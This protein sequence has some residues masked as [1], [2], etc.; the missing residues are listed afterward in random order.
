MKVSHIPFSEVPFFSQMDRDYVSE[1]DSLRS[2]YKYPV[3]PE[4]FHDVIKERKSF[5]VDR[6]L[7]VDV[8]ESQ[9]KKLNTS[10]EQAPRLLDK[11]CFT[12]TTAHQPCLFTGPLYF[13]YK[14]CSAIH[15]SH[16]LKG[17]YPEYDFVPVFIIGG[18]D[19]DF[20]EMNHAHL[21]SRKITWENTESGPVGRMSSASLIPVLEEVK[22]ILGQSDHAIQLV[23]LLETSFSPDRT[24]GEC[25]QKF[26]I[27]LFRSQ[28]LIVLSMDSIQ[29]KKAFAGTMREEL[30]NNPSHALVKGTQEELT[31]KGFKTQAHAREINL[32]Y[33][34]ENGRDRI[35]FSD[36]KF[37]VLNQGISFTKDEIDQELDQYPERFS[38]NV[39]LRPLYQEKIL[40]NLAYI[41]GG[42]EIAY[43]LERKAQFAHFNLPF[44]MLIRRNSVIWID[45]RSVKM[46]KT[47]ELSLKE[48]FLPT[49]KIIN[50]W[51]QQHAVDE[52]DIDSE[53]ETVESAY[54]SIGEKANKLDPTL[55][56]AVEAERVKHIKL[57][58]HLG[59]RL[60]RAEKHKFETSTG[61]IRKLREKLFPGNG[62]Q[63]RYENFMPY[64]L[65]FGNEYI[66][67]LSQHLDPLN[68][69]VVLV[70]E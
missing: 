19:H 61:K 23:D 48:L 34:T 17:I 59:K 30:F 9:Y 41:G 22:G 64:Y 13:L 4:S 26:V 52:I 12:I 65:K 54:A 58:E 39:I 57:I 14:I 8:I 16:K 27:E 56:K 51:V 68:K 35:E 2:F 18:E 5:P 38:P 45:S 3:S 36:E 32:F 15:L 70:E 53:I 7:L 44:P 33:L 28:E 29:L 20:D 50:Q 69:N 47:F 21:F 46:M 67:F 49:D 25:M 24:Y 63:E 31:A 37:H 40:P 60:L 55:F 1:L 10:S 6:K 62:L 11:R 66:D 43:W 42:G